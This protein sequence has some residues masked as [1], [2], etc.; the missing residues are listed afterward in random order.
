MK[1]SSGK[2]GAIDVP[3]EEDK[4]FIRENAKIECPPGEVAKY[5]RIFEKYPGIYSRHQ[6]D[7]GRC[8]LLQHEIHLKDKAPVYIKQFKIPEGH[9]T[10]VEDQVTEWLKLGIFEP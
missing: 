10:A 3:T 2:K 8:D 4:R 5:L 9:A 1:P 6:N 7:L